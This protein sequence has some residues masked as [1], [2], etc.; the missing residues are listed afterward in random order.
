[1]SPP[2]RDN[3]IHQVNKRHSL[4][5]YEPPKRIASVLPSLPSRSPS[6]LDRYRPSGTMDAYPGYRE[7]SSARSPPERTSWS[8]RDEYRSS[9]REN[10]RT[11]TFYRGRSP[12]MFRPITLFFSWSHLHSHYRAGNGLP[13]LLPQ[14]LTNCAYCLPTCISRNLLTIVLTVLFA[15]CR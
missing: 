15:R 8:G 7:S 2:G 3:H 14:S 9:E 6:V 1:L 4:G 13:V 12:G 10:P 5:R 11:D